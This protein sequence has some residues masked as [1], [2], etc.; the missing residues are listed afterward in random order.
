MNPK[1]KLN[2]L[3]GK[4]RLGQHRDSEYLGSEDIDDDATP[5]LTISTLWNGLV[6]LR[7]G[8]ENKDVISF[9]EEKVDGMSQVRPLIV[10]A[11]NRKT[12]RKLY[13]GVTASILVG[14]RV[15]LFIDHKVRDPQ[16]GGLTDGVRIKKI[17][18]PGEEINGAPKCSDCS[19][20]IKSAGKLSTEQ[21]VAYGRKRFGADLCADCMKKRDQANKE[22]EP[23][24]VIEEIKSDEPSEFEQAMKEQ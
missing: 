22:P 20:E 19:N 8:K 18:P 5:I 21:M 11:T 10:N 14:K 6:T 17:I 15:Q 2:Q 3:K 4:E 9:K 13:K 16:D 23:E 12:L 24:E 7:R 1:D